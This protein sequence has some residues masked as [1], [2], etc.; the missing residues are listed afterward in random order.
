MDKNNVLYS[1]KETCKKTGLTYDTLKFYCNEGLIPNVKRNK[2]NY[3][4]FDDKD[5]NWI[6][7]LSCLKKCGMSIVEMKEYLE[8]CIKGKSTIPERQ[9]ILEAKLRELEH[10]KDEIQDSINFIHW[11]QNFYKNVLSGK[12]KY[13]SYLIPIE[14]DDK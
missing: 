11:K 4:V 8:L 5:I 6:K 7:N 3:R 9:L 2:S 13:F 1:M 10:K 12:E 14:N